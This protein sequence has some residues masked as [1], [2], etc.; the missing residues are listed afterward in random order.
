MMRRVAIGSV[1]LILPFAVWTLADYVETRR[2]ARLVDEIR[3]RGEAI[4]VA[5]E[6]PTPSPRE[7]AA[8]YYEAAAA[9]VDLTDF[10]G[11]TGL[12]AQF[13]THEERVRLLPDVRTCLARN[14]DAERLLTNASGFI[15]YEPHV[16]YNLRLNG[17]LQL[18][19]LADLR[20]IERIEAADADGAA[21]AVVQ[22]VTIA[23]V[24]QIRAG[25]IGMLAS[26]S[27][28]GR[29]ALT[30]A[31]ALELGVSP[32][33][34]A[35]LQSAFEAAD[36]DDLIAQLVIAERAFVLGRYWN[37][38]VGSFTR[39]TPG[40]P[41]SSNAPDLLWL[42]VNPYVM[43]L[44][45]GQVHAM[46]SLVGEA[47]RP[48]PERVVLV[49]P[50]SAQEDRD[51]WLFPFTDVATRRGVFEAHARRT[52]YAAATLAVVRSA[53]SVLAVERFRAAHGA[54]PA[55]L[56]DLIPGELAGMRTD[57]F[58]GRPL[59]FKQWPDGYGVYSV[60]PDREDD[61]GESLGTQ[62][63][64]YTTTR[65]RT[66]PADVGIRIRQPQAERR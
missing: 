34:I 3:A 53:I 10:H 1:I 19:R 41:W 18:A 59:V 45:I 11:H 15:A 9:L 48:W 21:D 2:M 46:T 32:S 54:L 50:E 16:E 29:A 62:L 30:T 64:P 58:S 6:Y 22:Q 39:F 20:A 55:R 51:A 61:R 13:P 66:D 23:R 37:S 43:H 17:L 12:L 47:R 44:V 4:S 5:P 28:I 8:P 36:R 56:A 42:T 49:S 52:R 25:D 31:A 63:G 35:R 24:L 65:R 33:A 40:P 60:G 14:A 38:G 57:P 27:V 26:A 7:N